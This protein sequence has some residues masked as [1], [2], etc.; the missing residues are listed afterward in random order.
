MSPRGKRKANE[1]TLTSGSGTQNIPGAEVARQIG[2]A[3]GWY[4]RYRV[5][6]CLCERER[7]KPVSAMIAKA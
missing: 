2:R 6:C 3:D 1:D 4:G 7:R 5:G